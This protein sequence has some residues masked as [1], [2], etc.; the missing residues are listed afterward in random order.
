MGK[1]RYKLVPSVK[2]AALSTTL[3]PESSWVCQRFIPPSLNFTGNTKLLKMGIL[4]LHFGP[5]N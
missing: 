4:E 3:E 5:G 2:V 1:K